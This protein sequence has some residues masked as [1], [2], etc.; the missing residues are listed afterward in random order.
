[1][2]QIMLVDDEAQLLEGLRRSLHHRH[3]WQ[4]DLF[5][6]PI[7]ALEQA[8]AVEYDLI[9]SDYQMPSMDGVTFLKQVRNLLPDS[10]R[11]ILSGTADLEVII[12]AI[13]EAGIYRFISKPVQ[14]YDLVATIDQALQY[15]DTLRENKRLADLVRKQQYE[16]KKREQVLVQF[17]KQHPMLANVNWTDD[18]SILLEEI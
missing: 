4:V 18:G 16:L 3:D 8:T 15:F 13:N 12:K 1:M 14:R 6:N 11:L 2:Y 5:D 10:I 7:R 17:A 9:I